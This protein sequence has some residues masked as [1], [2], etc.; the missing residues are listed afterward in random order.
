M[1][2][3]YKTGECVL[4]VSCDRKDPAIIHSPSEQFKKR[5][6]ASRF[7]AHGIVVL[8][9]F[10]TP[11]ITNI[12]DL[13]TR[14]VS[15]W[16][17]NEVKLTKKEFTIDIL[18]F[19]TQTGFEYFIGQLQ[20]RVRYTKKLIRHPVTNA[21]LRRIGLKFINFNCAHRTML[22]TCCS[23]VFDRQNAYRRML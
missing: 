22:E 16:P 2:D 11:L 23:M 6:Q 4:Q 8:T 18:I 5:R 21:L 13:S 14:G 7:K 15:F 12:Y 3:K 10:K 20:G 19:D 1:I 17:I 9:D